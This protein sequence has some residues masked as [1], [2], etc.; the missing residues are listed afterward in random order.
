ML[1]TNRRSLAIWLALAVLLVAH[2]DYWQWDDTS[3]MFGFLPY[4]L[5]Y[6]AVI[7]V[8]AAVVWFL[9]IVFCWPASLDEM[10]YQAAKEEG[11]P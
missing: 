5:F 2:Q 9:A 11:R 10:E 7:S 8:L 3:L 4:T 1:R 6:H